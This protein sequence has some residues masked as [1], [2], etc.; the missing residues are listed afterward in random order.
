MRRLTLLTLLALALVP[1]AASGAGCSPLSCAPFATSIAGTQLLAVQEKGVTSAVRI[2]D[3]ADGQTRWNLPSGILAGTTLVTKQGASV[4]W[5]DVTTGKQTASQQVAQYKTWSLAGASMDGKRAV[6]VHSTRRSPKTSFALVGDGT[7][8]V[9]LPGNWGFDALT[10]QKMYVLH[11]LRLG[12]EVRLYDLAR[13]V[14]VKKAVKNGDEG[15]LI[16]G[17][18]WTRL[19]SADGRYVFTLYIDEASQAMIHELDLRS[20]TARCIDLPGDGDFNGASGYGL[21]LS[22]DGKTVW[23]ASAAYGRVA[24][25]D[26]A[27][28]KVRASFSFAPHKTE[29][30]ASPAIALNQQGTTLA[31]SVVGHTYFLD[32]GAKR[33]R[34]GPTKPAIAI[35]F[36]PDGRTLWAIDPKNGTVALNVPS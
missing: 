27:S 11:Y 32:L 36:S 4:G 22:A 1:S 30:P 34:V 9:T 25:V 35:G 15:T 8:V 17:L 23:A 13:N 3:L 26:V 12:Y 20:G 5:V 31:L 24:A 21:A 14:L 7:R 19:D 6:L 2:V 28:A 18:P 33:M 16:K 10:G 29:N